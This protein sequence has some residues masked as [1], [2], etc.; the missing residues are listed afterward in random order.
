ML[1]LVLAATPVPAQQPVYDGLDVDLDPAT[2]SGFAVSVRAHAPLGSSG[3]AFESLGD[4]WGASSALTGLFGERYAVRL[5]LGIASLTENLVDVAGV[6]A[7]RAWLMDIWGQMLW[8]R[9]VGRV[10]LEAGPAV[11][12]ARLSRSALASTQGGFLVAAS[13]GASLAL[14]TRWMV[15]MDGS[16]SWA[17][18]A[19]PE[20]A[21]PP[22]AGFQDEGAGGRILC[23]GLGLA[24]RWGGP[25]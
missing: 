8:R 7:D 18:F 17:D 22:P 11:G 5:R 21:V 4:G 10:G 23:L 14:G 16:A 13:V 20:W 2:I 3:E 19:A 24:Y 25:T 12:Y 1:L 9:R 15:V 6:R